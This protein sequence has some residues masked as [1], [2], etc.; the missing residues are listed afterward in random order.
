MDEIENRTISKVA[1]WKKNVFNNMDKTRWK[2]TVI[3]TC[4]GQRWHLRSITTDLIAI[5]SWQVQLVAYGPSLDK[6]TG[7]SLQNHIVLY[8]EF[9]KHWEH[10]PNMW[11]SLPNMWLSL[12]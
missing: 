2:K 1:G 5:V 3:N 9:T 6:T 8:T 11:L 12:S 7:A 10:L 4:V